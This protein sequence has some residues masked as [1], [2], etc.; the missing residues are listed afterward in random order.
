MV[1]KVR[2][3]R[4]GV[5]SGGGCHH[6]NKY[7]AGQYEVSLTTTDRKYAGTGS[8]IYYTFVGTK[9]STPEFLAP[10]DRYQG[11]TDVLTFSDSTDIG[12]FKC[13]NIRIGGTDGWHIQEVRF[14]DGWVFRYIVRFVMNFSIDVTV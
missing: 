14:A 13:L 1:S 10:G 7:L 4:L 8:L 11:R 2:N 9:A 6:P 5:F 12:E 3:V